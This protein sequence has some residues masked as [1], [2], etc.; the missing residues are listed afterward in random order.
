M[1]QHESPTGVHVFP[2][3]N[4]PPWRRSALGFLWKEWCESWNSSTLATSCEELT[5]WKRLWCWEGLG[6][7]G[8]G[9]MTEDEMVG[10]HHQLDGCEFG[11]ALGVAD[12]QG[13]LACCDSWGANSQTRLSDWTELNW[14]CV[15]AQLCLTLCDPLDYSLPGSS[16]H[17]ILQARILECVAIPFSNNLLKDFLNLP[18][19]PYLRP[20]TNPGTRWLYFL[21]ISVNSKHWALYNTNSI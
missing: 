2:I 21:V 6:A 11:W 12:G 9:D 3:L 18:P 19:L 16:V 13:G 17:G 5:H 20:P 1:H 4:T 14:K 10:W 8:E 15:S 7:G